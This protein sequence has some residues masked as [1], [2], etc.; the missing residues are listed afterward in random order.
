MENTRKRKIIYT[1]LFIAILIM[2]VLVVVIFRDHAA[3]TKYS[4]PSI[5]FAFCSTVYAIIAIALR[6]QFDLFFL[7]FI[8]NW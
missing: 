3:I 7:K 5:V 2:N 1:S 6:E 8:H 4:I